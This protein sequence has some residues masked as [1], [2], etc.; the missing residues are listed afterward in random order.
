VCSSS[1]AGLTVTL[2]RNKPPQGIVDAMH[3][4]STDTVVAE[5]SYSVAGV[6]LPVVLHFSLHFTGT[7]PCTFPGAFR[8]RVIAEAWAGLA[9]IIAIAAVVIVSSPSV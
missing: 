3:G 1:S 2:L 6:Y 9:G 7:R 5:I 4:D 8:A